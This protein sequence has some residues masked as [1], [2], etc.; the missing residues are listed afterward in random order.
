MKDNL[1]KY[2]LLTVFLVFVALYYSSG[3]GLIDYQSRNK[4][5]LTEEQIKQFEEDVA[6]NV[7]IDL[8]NYITDSE[9]KYDNS[10]SKNTLKLSN[11][12]GETI[13]E[14]LDFLFGK[15]EDVMN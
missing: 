13:Q 6:N 5:A 11:K 8:K 15:M 10:I 7:E 9:E 3:S 2:V 12:I 14:A 4:M 1:F